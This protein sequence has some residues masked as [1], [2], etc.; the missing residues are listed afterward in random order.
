[1]KRQAVQSVPAVQE[2]ASTAVHSAALQPANAAGERLSATPRMVA[3]AQAISAGFGAAAHLPGPSPV[4][5]RKINLQ[6]GEGEVVNDAPLER[7]LTFLGTSDERD[8]TTFS[9]TIATDYG[10]R[11]ALKRLIERD[12]T[13][14]YGYPQAADLMAA[15][16]A[17]ARIT[18]RGD[19]YELD[20]TFRGQDVARD[21]VYKV[22]RD[23]ETSVIKQGPNLANEA[24]I[25]AAVAGHENVINFLDKEDD[26]SKIR[27]E[28]AAQGTLSNYAVDSEAKA[29]RLARGIIAGLSHVHGR[30]VVH[31]DV[32]KANIF[33]GGT[34]EEP[35]AKIADFGES[36]TG[37]DAI[38]YNLS[39][40]I[41]A[42]ANA[43]KGLAEP[44]SATSAE[45]HAFVQL[46]QQLIDDA[47]DVTQKA[48]L[49]NPQPLRELAVGSGL[50]GSI[51][52]V[53][54]EHIAQIRN[55]FE[56]PEAGPAP[57]AD[58]IDALRTRWSA[59]ANNAWLAH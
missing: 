52:T 2:S 57:D 25:S 36:M 59:L 45:A 56:L 48:S 40:D 11:E 55:M 50:A 41:S 51:E 10:L 6:L 38:T 16:R 9:N 7:V 22:S 23:D 49:A 43:L 39:S 46:L 58:E 3:Q 18:H 20:K 28:Y 15:V 1:V 33:V 53:T 54:E 13:V 5:Q 30:G 44:F 21:S 24:A 35:V 4:V 31:G 29:K 37:A 19:S 17:E 42:G 34:A 26:N 27:L 32:G 8:G 47:L 12:A 14:T